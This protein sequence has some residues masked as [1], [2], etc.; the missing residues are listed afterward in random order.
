MSKSNN[1][2]SFSQMLTFI[3]NHTYFLILWLKLEYDYVIKIK[4][5]LGILQGPYSTGSTSERE[6]MQQLRT[7]LNF[8]L[9]ISKTKPNSNL[10]E[11]IYILMKMDILLIYYFKNISLSFFFHEI[12]SFWGVVNPYNKNDEPQF[13]PLLLVISQ[14]FSNIKHVSGTIIVN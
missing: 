14:K 8:V 4:N 5:M 3:Q 10:L 7:I 6:Y 2:S 9:I 1:D 13:M 12:W 11:T